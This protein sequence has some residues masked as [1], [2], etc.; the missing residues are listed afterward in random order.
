MDKLNKFNRRKFKIAFNS[1]VMLTFSLICLAAFL[2]D[3]LTRGGANRLFFSVYRSSMLSPM[4][5]VRMVFHV[6]GHS[7]WEHL[8]GNITLLLVIGPLLEEKY[9]SAN[10]VLVMLITAIVTG[11]SNCLFFPNVALLGASGVVFAFILLSSITSMK[12]GQ[13]PLTFLLVAVIYFGG[14]IYNGIF[15][16]DNISNITH[17][18]G[19]AVGGAAGFMLN[20]SK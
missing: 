13:I 9:G 20:R 11:V 16:R 4:T 1:P 18:L 14:E 6:F 7:G 15:V 2:L 10:M 12:E 8:F 19:G 5:Y 17:I 3:V